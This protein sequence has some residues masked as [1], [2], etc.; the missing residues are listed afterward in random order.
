M[1]KINLLSEKKIPQLPKQLTLFQKISLLY[2]GKN[3]NQILVAALIMATFLSVFN[4]IMASGG[5]RFA[6]WYKDLQKVETTGIVTG[7]Y[8]REDRDNHRTIYK[9][10]FSY[11]DE[12]K[13]QLNAECYTFD[14]DAPITYL[15]DKSYPAEYIVGYRETAHLVGTS[16]KPVIN[17]SDEAIFYTLIAIWVGLCLLFVGLAIKNWRILTIFTQWKVTIAEPQPKET[18]FQGKANQSLPT[19]RQA[20]IFWDETDTEHRVEVVLPGAGNEVLADESWEVVLYNPQQPKAFFLWDV[21]LAFPKI[22]PDGQLVYNKIWYIWAMLFVC[23][24][25]TVLAIFT[26]DSPFRGLL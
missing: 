17:K 22:N 15:E 10:H 2:S 23:L 3:T 4:L 12:K 20:F 9:I 5:H 7:C 25:C 26:F 24:L 16:P 13:Q 19:V 21:E 1:S 8:P 14:S 6:H 11:V 18:N